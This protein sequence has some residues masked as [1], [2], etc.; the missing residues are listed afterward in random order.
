VTDLNRQTGKPRPTVEATE[1]KTFSKYQAA[2]G[3]R[4]KTTDPRIRKKG[5]NS[6]S[7]LGPKRQS[8]KKL[9]PLGAARQSS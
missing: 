8:N 3:V 7:N 4:Q 6:Q 1:S 2:Q 5:K 9:D